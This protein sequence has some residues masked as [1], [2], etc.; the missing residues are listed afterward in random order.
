MFKFGLMS[1]G[2]RSKAVLGRD[3][4]RL[5]ESIISLENR[6][7]VVEKNLKGALRLSFVLADH[8]N[9]RFEDVKEGYKLV[10]KDKNKGE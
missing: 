9:L 8:F 5:N 2:E 3:I 10:E 6:I 7:S 1:E 4:S